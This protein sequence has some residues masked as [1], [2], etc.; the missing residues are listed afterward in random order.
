M[1]V[2]I[3]LRFAVAF[4][5]ATPLYA[6]ADSF[7][8]KPGAWEMTVTTLTSGMLIPP[9]ALANMPP[10][11]RARLEKA[12]QAR[13]GKPHTHV[14]K[15][16]VTKESLDQDRVIKSDDEEHCKKKVISKSAKKIV[17]EETCGDPNP[18]KSNVMME[19]STPE[20]MQA[21]MDMVR[22]KADEGR[23]QVDFKGKWLGASC[24]GIKD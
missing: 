22:G 5:V 9:E 14:T 12:K 20:S 2:K 18:S 21:H 11:Q 8:M 3:L 17:Y 15:S 10:A 19:A 13:E 23:I 16:C 24:A 6:L 1:S 7:N 4:A